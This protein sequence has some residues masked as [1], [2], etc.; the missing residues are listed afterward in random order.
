MRKDW[1]FVA[2]P[3]YLA[4]MRETAEQASGVI[5]EMRRRVVAAERALAE[6]VLAAGGAVSVPDCQ[7][8]RIDAPTLTIW[9]NE[10]DQTIEFRARR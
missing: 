4:D 6:V 3:D 8:Q 7:R 5:T 9:R 10:K 2:M 1:D